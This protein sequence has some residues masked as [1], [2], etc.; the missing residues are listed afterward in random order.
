MLSDV[1]ITITR[2]IVRITRRGFGK[3]L[4]VNF[5]ENRA[6]A[7]C[8]N[9]SDVEEVGWDSSSDIHKMATAIFRQ[10]PSPPEIAVYG[11]HVNEDGVDAQAFLENS[12]G[13]GEIT[14][15]ADTALEG[16][17]G[18]NIK[19]V[20]E[21]SGSGGLSADYNGTDKI[22][23]FDFGGEA[24]A[25]CTEIVG[26]INAKDNFTADTDT[27]TKTFTVADDMEATATTSGGYNDFAGGIGMVLS[28]LTEEQNEWYFLLS[29]EK[30]DMKRIQA[31][32]NFAAGNNKLY[33]TSPDM[34]VA[35][36][37]VLANKLNTERA[38]LIY[39]DE[40]DEHADAAWVGKC[41]PYDP[42]SITWKFKSLDGVTV[43]ELTTTQVNALHNA[44]VNTYVS[45]LGVEQTSEGMTTKMDQ[46]GYIDVVRG[47]DWVEARMS[48]AVHELLFKMP[49]VPFTNKG[50]GMVKGTIEAVL[51]WATTRGIVAKDD[52]GHGMFEVSVPDRFETQSID[53]A[54]R[55]LKDVNFNFYLAGA[56]H[57][58]VIK[59]VI[60]I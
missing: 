17:A 29:D 25:T 21:D 30:E 52:D 44:H 22:L 4:L 16:A 56:I 1:Q 41:A 12:A 50:I 51:Q 54:N 43:P 6:Y 60:R 27:G 24:S 47:Q 38:A 59:G 7:D 11:K 14:I 13:D 28:E 48:E 9:M 42:G 8:R 23:T 26:V 18:N 2:E 20:F 39:N 37:I 33:F 31:L 45:K 5:S 40:M 35:N 3:P 53:R 57:E 10:T 34:S 32:S 19:V 36:Y 15:T 58:V 46:S 49:K 55:I